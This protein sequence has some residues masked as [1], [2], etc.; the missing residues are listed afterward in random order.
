MNPHRIAQIATFTIAVVA[1]SSCASLDV[2]SYVARGAN[3]EQYRTF[4]WVPREELNTGDARLDNNRFF[5]DRVRMDVERGLAARGFEKA[6]DTPDML[7]Q[8]HASVSQQIDWRESDRQYG[9]CEDN[10]CRPFV[11]D[12]GTLVIDVVNAQTRRLV[13]RGWAKDAFAGVVDNQ[14]VME[15][16]IDE[17]VRRILEKLPRSL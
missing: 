1:V 12:V 15:A 14:S 13:W 8:Y 11:D 4:A 6:T 5:D 17:A 3:V 7:I 10:D 16:R 2:R 9:T